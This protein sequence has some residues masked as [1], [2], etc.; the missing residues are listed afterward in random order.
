MK[1]VAELEAAR[2]AEEKKLMELAEEKSQTEKA[3]REQ[4]KI[5]EKLMRDLV[6]A[7]SREKS[8]EKKT[9]K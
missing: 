8:S 5:C 1:T 9:S 7:Y 3:Y 4:K 6:E 2:S